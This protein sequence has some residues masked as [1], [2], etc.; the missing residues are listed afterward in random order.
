VVESQVSDGSGKIV[1][2]PEAD[3]QRPVIGQIE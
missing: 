2:R 3:E 1:L